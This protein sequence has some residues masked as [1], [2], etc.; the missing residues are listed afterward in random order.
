MPLK[1]SSSG[2]ITGIVEARVYNSSGVLQ[3][4][5]DQ[6]DVSSV[7]PSFVL[8]EFTFST[9]HTFA[10]G[11]FIGVCRVSGGEPTMDLLIQFSDTTCYANT[12]SAAINP[13]T[14]TQYTSWDA[15]FEA[16]LESSTSGGARLPPPPAF[17]RI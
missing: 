5:S 1:K 3:Q 4:S 16:E 17:V 10:N 8:Y 9:S 2:V 14:I 6:F 15:I 13:P 11:D 7:T 12:N